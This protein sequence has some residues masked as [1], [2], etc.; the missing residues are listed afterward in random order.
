MMPNHPSGSAG[1]ADAPSFSSFVWPVS[2][3]VMA[4]IRAG[5]RPD[6]FFEAQEPGIYEDLGD[7]AS[8]GAPL[9]RRGDAGSGRPG[10]GA[11]GHCA[12]MPG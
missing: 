3:V 2:D 1:E 7:T 12:V 4:F 8:A 5:L 9:T 6:E 11:A 10:R